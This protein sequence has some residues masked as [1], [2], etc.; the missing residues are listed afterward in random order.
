MAKTA[1]L[2]LTVTPVIVDC[3]PPASRTCWDQAPV[4]R[5]ITGKI[6]CLSAVFSV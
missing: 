4:T 1:L 2:S 3:V 6:S 5:I